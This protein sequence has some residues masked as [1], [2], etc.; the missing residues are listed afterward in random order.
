MIRW[1]RERTNFFVA[2]AETFSPGTMDAACPSGRRDDPSPWHPARQISKSLAKTVGAESTFCL[3]DRPSIH[4]QWQE[5]ALEIKTIDRAD[6]FRR[7]FGNMDFRQ[8]NDM[9]LRPE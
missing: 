9:A 7:P 4:G 8:Q 2:P 6:E 5:T 1:N 3:M